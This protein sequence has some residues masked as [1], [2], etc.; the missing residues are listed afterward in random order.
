MP[1][2]AAAQVTVVVPSFNQ[3]EFL[4]QA[5]AS[6]FEQEVPV[7]VLVLD[8][9]STDRSLEV[10]E[11]WAPRLAW[12]CSGPDAG[13]SWAV[14]AGM[15]RGSAP[16][17]CW[18]NADDF[19][20]PGAL[21]AMLAVLEAN[22]AAPAVYGRAWAVS[23]SGGKL[24]PYPT[25]AFSPWWLAQ[26]C[27]I[28][29]PATLMRRTAWETIGGVDENLHMAMDYDLWWRLYKHGGKLAY[30]RRFIAATRMHR[31]TKTATRREDHYREAM[32]VLQRHL[33]Y[34]PLKWR[35]AWP[36]MVTARSRF[37]F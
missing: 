28:A 8:G 27:F 25:M 14:N 33:G 3:G 12:W 6:I 30:V 20:Y 10:I 13:Q 17:V 18:L 16:Y 22:P 31:N 21:K 26:Y 34:V 35:L 5:L 7:E 2:P 4:G 15:R 37:R 19:F 24:V 36:L 32:A 23:E 29:Q 1:N 9:G 11:A